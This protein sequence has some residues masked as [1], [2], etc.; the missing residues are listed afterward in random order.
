MGTGAADAAGRRADRGAGGRPDQA[1]ALHRPPEVSGELRD[2]RALASDRR[3]RR[4]RRP[5]RSRSA[6]ATSW[7]K[8]AA[9]NKTL[10]VG[11]FAL[12]PAKMNHFAYTRARKRRS[13]STAGTG[14][15]QVREPG[16]RSAEQEERVRITDVPLRLMA[17]LAHPDD[18][19]LGFGG[20]LAKYAAEG[21]DVFLVT[22]TRGE[23]GR[24]RG[25]RPDDRRASRAGGARRASARRS[26]AP[27][28]RCWACA[29]SRCSTITTSTSIARTRARRSRRIVGASAAR[30]ARRR[31]DVRTR[32]RLRPSRSHRDLPVH[33]RGDR[34]RG[35]SRVRRRRRRGRPPHAV[36]KLYYIAWPRIDVGGLSGRV[37]EA[38]RRRS[39]ASSGRRCRGPTGRSR[40]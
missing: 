10:A 38:R 18:E 11:G 28:P 31:H 29:R 17:V 5:A 1:G 40:R 8:G 36:S 25:H 33:D 35:R 9:A 23:R 34:R 6:W 21:V 14:G 12:M 15:V 3:E 27:P 32:R 7:T 19:S 22:A 20:T 16:G 26:C 4:R 37:P 30:P 2:S 24:Y 39:T 13:C